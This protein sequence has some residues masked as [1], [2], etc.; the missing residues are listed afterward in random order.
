MYFFVFFTIYFVSVTF[1]SRQQMS[2]KNLETHHPQINQNMPT[3]WISTV[4][5]SHCI[6]PTKELCFKEKYSRMKEADLGCNKLKLN[7]WALIKP[8]SVISLICTSTTVNV[9]V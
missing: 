5:I 2:V 7:R 9:Q 6:N 4:E 1:H 8:F 3:K